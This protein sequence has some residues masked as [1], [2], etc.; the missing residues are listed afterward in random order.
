MDVQPISRLCW[1]QHFVTGAEVCGGGGG[2][3]EDGVEV[4][5]E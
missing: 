2:L 4:Q 5:V 3:A 1:E